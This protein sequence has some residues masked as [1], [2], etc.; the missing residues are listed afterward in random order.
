MAK[1]DDER[2]WAMLCHLTAF[3][4]FVIPFGNVVGP[5]IVWLV[6]KDEYPGVKD[7]GRESVN[8]QIS[9]TIYILVAVMFSILLIGIPFLIGLVIFD[10]I[11]V[12]QAIV[13]ANEGK[14]HRYPLNLRL[15]G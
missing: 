13:S 12:I 4:G 1:K 5:L 2:T 10:M 7:Q 11:A 14:R 6:K 15:V 8:F 9:M 3:A